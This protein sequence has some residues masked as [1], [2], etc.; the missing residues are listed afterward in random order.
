MAQLSMM[1]TLAQYLIGCFKPCN[2]SEQV[3]NDADEADGGPKVNVT[4]TNVSNVTC[5]ASK[6]ANRNN[7]DVYVKTGSPSESPTTITEFC[8]QAEPG[9]VIKRDH[10]YKLP[11]TDETCSKPIFFESRGERI[12]FVDF[13][14]EGKE[15]EGEEDCCQSD[16][17]TT[18]NFD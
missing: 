12:V 17:N 16:V 9:I 2:S 18:R 3:N 1:T 13:L 10:E 6:A 7:D 4:T 5:C 8:A 14:F 11:T 15:E